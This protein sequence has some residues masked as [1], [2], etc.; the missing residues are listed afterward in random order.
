MIH[1][2]I[3]LPSW[4]SWRRGER[5]WALRTLNSSKSMTPSSSLP[6]SC[7]SFLTRY[8]SA[9]FATPTT[10]S[11]F[12][13]SWISCCWEG[14]ERE[15][16]KLADNAKRPF[17]RE[18]RVRIIELRPIRPTW[19]RPSRRRSPRASTQTRRSRV[20]GA[21][22][23]RSSRRKRARTRAYHVD[24]AGAVHVVEAE[25]RIYHPLALRRL[26][27]HALDVHGDGRTS[28]RGRGDARARAG[29][30]EARSR[31]RGVLGR[32][33]EVLRARDGTLVGEGALVTFADRCRGRGRSVGLCPF[34]FLSSHDAFPRARPRRRTLRSK[35]CGRV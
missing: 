13:S 22:A 33:R 10:R 17:G 15:G 26:V 8:L 32:A 7:M 35:P 5:E 1:F 16:V 2:W 23:R 4:S 14:R 11:S 12:R 29:S 27:H 34:D 21:C 28:G 24:S 20:A 31:A 9:S 6:S 19:T 3:L 25:F 18:R 30:K